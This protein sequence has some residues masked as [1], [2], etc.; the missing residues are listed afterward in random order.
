MSTSSPVAETEGICV[1]GNQ[2]SPTTRTTNNAQWGPL[3]GRS[4]NGYGAASTDT[5]MERLARILGWFSLGLG[6]AQIASPNRVA[7]LIGVDDDDATITMMRVVGARE[8][9]SGIGILTQPKPTPWLW[10]RVGGDAMDLALLRSA[11]A[12]PR[13]DQ[14]RVAAATAAVLGIAAVD[15]LCSTRLTAEPD[16]PYE[17][18][19]QSGAVH[20]TSAV[21]VNAPI[22]TVYG[23]WEDF[24]S[25]P[26]FMGDFAS[27]QVSGNRHSHWSLTAPAGITLEWDVEITE[28]ARNEQIAWRTSE[29]SHLDASGVVRFR[30]APANRGTEVLFDAQFNPPGGEL[31]KKIAGFFADALGTKIGNDLRRFKQ[32]VELGE[33]VHSD[34]SLIPGPNPAQPPRDIPAGRTQSATAS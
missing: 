28:T 15:A 8:I 19:H 20:A 11:M 12:S 5:E 26:R 16:A 18:V 7:Q 29:G 31:G 27:V 25:L 34:D 17:T 10:A 9:A 6:L 24:Q 22:D 30:T 32:L 23:Y 2:R 4:S 33:I 3:A 1:A 13:A 21:T 14:H